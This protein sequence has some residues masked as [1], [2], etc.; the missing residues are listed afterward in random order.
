MPNFFSGLRRKNL[1]V[2]T[3]IEKQYTRP[4]KLQLQTH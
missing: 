3:C 1:L 4:L 2:T